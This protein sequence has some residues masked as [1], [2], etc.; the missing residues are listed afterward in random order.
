MKN[1]ENHEFERLEEV[2]KKYFG[3]LSGLASVMDLSKTAIYQWRKRGIG[4]KQM[5]MLSDVGI[6]TDYIKAG[7]GSQMLYQIDKKVFAVKEKLAQY[8]ETNNAIDVYFDLNYLTP[9]Q[10]RQ[11]RAS[12]LR[13][14]EKIDKYLEG[15]PE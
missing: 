6:N 9:I 7:S 5:K 1:I 4:F 8:G 3:S 14:L 2:A 11:L 10:M 15:I 12:L 13:E